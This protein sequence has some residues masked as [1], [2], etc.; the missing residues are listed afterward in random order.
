MPSLTIRILVIAAWIGLTGELIRRDF[1]P[2]LLVGDPPDWKRVVESVPE[3]PSRW[4]I[5]VEE[6]PDRTRVVGQAVS[7][8][9]RRPDGGTILES[10]VR[11]DAKGLLRGTPLAVADST[12][13][14]F[15]S[16]TQITPQGLLDHMRGEV[17]VAELGEA[18]ILN[19]NAVATTGGKMD[20]RFESRLSPLMNFRQ[21]LDQDPRGMVRG[22]LEPIDRL[23]GLQVGQSW[24]T[25]VLQPLTAR[26]DTIRSEVTGMA[27]LFWNGNPTETFVVV[28]KSSSFS[29]RTWVR[30]DGLVIRQELPTPLVRLVLEREAEAPIR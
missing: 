3:A 29:A 6:S 25:R 28:H 5:S 4:M 7:E 22:G 9:R 26:P 18:P 21:T 24:T 1:L 16:T 13:F 10:R 23:P 20:V 11:I 8:S 27:R 17:V 12:E 2:E 30:R 14:V 19:V 15:R